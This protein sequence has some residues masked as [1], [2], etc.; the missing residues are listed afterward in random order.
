MLVNPY[1]ILCQRN[2]VVVW[3][4]VSGD[5]GCTTAINKAALEVRLSPARTLSLFLID[6]KDN[7]EETS[8]SLPYVDR[9]RHSS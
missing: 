2:D 8:G 7:S 6:K 5:R 1:N 4:E 9:T 3:L